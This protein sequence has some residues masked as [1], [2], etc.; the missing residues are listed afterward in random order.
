MLADNPN[1][2][3]SFHSAV[4]ASIGVDGGYLPLPLGVVVGGWGRLRQAGMRFPVLSEEQLKRHEEFMEAY[5]PYHDTRDDSPLWAFI[6][7][8]LRQNPDGVRRVPLTTSQ[9]RT[10]ARE[11]REIG[12]L[13]P[14]ETFML[15]DHPERWLDEDAHSE[16]VNIVRS[17]F[18]KRGSHVSALAQLAKRNNA[19]S[20]EYVLMDEI[21]NILGDRGSRLLPDEEIVRE[22]GNK[23]RRKPQQQEVKELAA[24]ANSET[25]L[26]SLKAAG[27][28]PQELEFARLLL[29]GMKPVEASQRMGSTPNH[30]RQIKHNISKKAL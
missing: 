7:E 23:I 4:S 2:Q 15:L 25:M 6:H 28:T 17:K 26:A 5:R 19:P 20:G 22:V 9:R 14:E 11:I 21:A 12:D 13:T 8:R 30:G 18:R 16:H 24:F 27:G 10:V 29:A 1:L 3:N